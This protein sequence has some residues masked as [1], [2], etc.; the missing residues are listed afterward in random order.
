M[1]DM[2]LRLRGEQGR[3]ERWQQ[4]VDA[5]RKVFFEKGFERTTIDDIEKASGLTRGAIY[6]HFKGKEEIYI[7]VLTCGLRLLR[8]ELR[9][10]LRDR[11]ASPEELVGRFFDKY[12]EFSRTHR[13]YMNILDHFHSGW[14]T[15]H[16]LPQNLVEE[17][18]RLFFECI[19][20]AVSV[21]ELGMK[22]GVFKVRDPFLETIMLWSMASSAL[23]KT[24]A[25]PRT[26]FL[27]VDWQT[28]KKA[29]KKR[30]L[31]SLACER[32]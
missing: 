30:I 10:T 3:R 2:S 11:N 20:E 26:A 24:T 1:T 17:V 31:S 19:N 28:M 4:I 13:E 7:S 9:W 6:Y 22:Q 12:S 25:N 27:G 23:R 29:L 8:D 18:N 21:V 32:I 5:A 14:E 16:E 15:Q